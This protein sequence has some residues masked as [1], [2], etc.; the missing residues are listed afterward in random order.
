MCVHRWEMAQHSAL[1]TTSPLCQLQVNTKAFCQASGIHHQS[2]TFQANDRH[3]ATRLQYCSTELFA[4]FLFLFW[5][6]VST[7]PDHSPLSSCLSLLQ[8]PP[9][10]SASLLWQ[11]GGSPTTPQS[12]SP[13]PFSLPPLALLELLCYTLETSGEHFCCP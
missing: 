11:I 3:R 12:L 9:T 1:P 5:G 10:P 8:A 4:S 6:V 2:F 13:T 7:L